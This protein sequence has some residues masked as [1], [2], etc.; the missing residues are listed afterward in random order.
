MTAL[1]DEKVPQV[2][3]EVGRYARHYRQEVGFERVYGTLGRVSAVH[4]GGHQLEFGAPLLGD[5]FFVLHARLVV[6]YLEVDAKA[7]G[8]E[9]RHDGVIRGNPVLVLTCFER[10]SQDGI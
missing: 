4:V 2:A 8:L 1:R 9:R 5:L 7:S 3:R 10:T 6:Q